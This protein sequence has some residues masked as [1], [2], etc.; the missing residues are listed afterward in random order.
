MNRPAGKLAG[1]R[2]I[3]HRHARLPFK[4]RQHHRKSRLFAP[5]MSAMTVPHQACMLVI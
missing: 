5:P 3:T 1:V 2:R 4:I